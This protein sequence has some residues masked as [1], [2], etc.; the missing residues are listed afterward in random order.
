MGLKWESKLS[1]FPSDKNI[2]SV[3]GC[4]LSRSY[5]LGGWRNRGSMNEAPKDTVLGVDPASASRIRAA[6]LSALGLDAEDVEGSPSSD[7]PIMA[8]AA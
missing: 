2:S 5:G 1:T 7:M 3:G 4:L 8:A 6:V